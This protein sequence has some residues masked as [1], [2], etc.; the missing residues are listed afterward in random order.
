LASLAQCLLPV[1]DHVAAH[2]LKSRLALSSPFSFVRARF[3]IDSASPAPAIARLD[4]AGAHCLPTPVHQPEPAARADQPFGFPLGPVPAAPESETAIDTDP[5]PAFSL[6]SGPFF[7]SVL[8]GS[9]DGIK[10]LRRDG[11]LEFMN[12]NGLCL[13]GDRRLRADEGQV[14]GGAVAGGIAVFA[15]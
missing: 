3:M 7:L 12:A 14:V 15:D 4:E 9:T 11:T 1:A 6:D 13:M 10:I 5:G 8:N 2:R